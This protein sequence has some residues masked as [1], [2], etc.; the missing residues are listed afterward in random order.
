MIFRSG[1][2]ARCYIELVE[3]RIVVAGG[4]ESITF[5]PIGRW[6]EFKE[7]LEEDVRI[8]LPAAACRKPCHC[9]ECNDEAISAG[10]AWEIASLRSQ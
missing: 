9:E 10:E 6:I 7:R 4:D 2:G 1:R 3:I 8:Q 5:H